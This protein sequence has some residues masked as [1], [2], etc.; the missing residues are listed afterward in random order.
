MNNAD[1]FI[2]LFFGHFIADY[3]LQ[4]DVIAINKSKRTPSGYFYC[5]M[6]CLLYA[7]IVTGFLYPLYTKSLV[8]FPFIFITHFLPDKYGWASKWMR[9]MRITVP[10]KY[11]PDHRNDAFRREYCIPISI[12]IDNVM[13]L[14]FMYYGIQIIQ[15][16]GLI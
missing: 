15:K 7:F 6:H 8:L 13:H 2:A 12:V 4:S 10:Q 14:A 3:F 16:V 9:L 11:I 5:T 1:L